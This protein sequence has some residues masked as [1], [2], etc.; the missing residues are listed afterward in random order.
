M[1][2]KVIP[3]AL[4]PGEEMMALHLRANKIAFER[5][6][7]FAPPRKWRFDFAILS[8]K[9]AI[10]VDGGIWSNGRHS[11]GTGYEND[12]RKL[13]EAATL[14]WRIIRV[15]PAMVHSGEA[16]NFVARALLR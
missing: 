13:S 10:E 14:G 6:Y 5:E 2:R 8:E 4:N 15:S 16:L 7:V 11:R 1:P 3:K 9:L 12:C